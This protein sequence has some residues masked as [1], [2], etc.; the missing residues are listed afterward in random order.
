[1]DPSAI[2]TLQG[3]FY[4]QP[5]LWT[6]AFQIFAIITTFITG[7]IFSKNSMASDDPRIKLKGKFLLIAFFSFTIGGALD[8]LLPFTPFTLVL[9]RLILISSAIEYY[10]GFLLPKRFSR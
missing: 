7:V 3:K 4:Y 10:L 8:A 1:M 9:V 2:G 5:K 6:M